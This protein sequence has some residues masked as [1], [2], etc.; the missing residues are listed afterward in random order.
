MGHFFPFASW[1]VANPKKWGAKDLT[2]R[3]RSAH[4]RFSND[5]GGVGPPL[6]FV[7]EGDE[8]RSPIL[9]GIFGI[10]PAKWEL[11]VLNQLGVPAILFRP[12]RQLTRLIQ[13]AVP[14]LILLTI[15]SG[16]GFLWSSTNGW[17]FELA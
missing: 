9:V 16:A 5:L 13:T 12:N 10:G 3:F 8:F 2:S 1:R 14:H 6:C 15:P 4:L 17:I 7:W 11:F